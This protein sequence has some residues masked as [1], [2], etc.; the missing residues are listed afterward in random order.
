MKGRAPNSGA[1]GSQE[2]VPPEGVS[3]QWIDFLIGNV[4]SKGCPL[5]I[6]T[7]NGKAFVAEA[8]T[9]T[10]ERFGIKGKQSTPYNPRGNG[11]A[12]RLVQTIKSALKKYGLTTVKSAKQALARV[13]FDYNTAVHSTTGYSPFFMM[14]KFEPRYP[15]ESVLGT[16]KVQS[17][18]NQAVKEGVRIGLETDLKARKKIAQAEASQDKRLDDQGKFDATKEFDIGDRVWIRNELARAALD[19]SYLGPGTIVGRLAP[20]AYLVDLNGTRKKVNIRKLTRYVP[21]TPMT[22]IRVDLGD[23]MRQAQ[24]IEPEET[25]KATQVRP[26]MK[27]QETVFID[28]VIEEEEPID[29]LVEEPEEIPIPLEAVGARQRTLTD[30][31]EAEDI[32][33]EGKMFALNAA[34]YWNSA[35]PRPQQVR[36]AVQMIRGIAHEQWINDITKPLAE[37]ETKEMRLQKIAQKIE[38]E[39]A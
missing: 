25:A 24:R 38:E 39:F 20:N 3:I 13:M 14:M 21:D 23:A 26:L 9:K 27:Q 5:T 1:S 28:E 10:Y 29:A 15:L 16:G 7:D 18:P 31:A 37:G 34:S 17:T 30:L 32:R 35:R 36:D 12:E 8:V 33:P 22:E 2:K 19:P 6:L 11:Q 4:F